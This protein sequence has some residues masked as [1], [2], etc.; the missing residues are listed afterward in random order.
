MTDAVHIRRIKARYRLQPSQVAEKRR[1]DSVLRKAAGEMLELALERAGVRSSE[2]ICIRTL[3][4]PVSLQ[5]SG[6]DSALAAEWATMLAKAIALAATDSLTCVRYRSHRLALID[7]GAN[8]AQGRLDRVWAWRQMGFWQRRE[9]PADLS[10]AVREFAEALR[11]EPQGIVAALAALARRGLLRPLAPYLEKSWPQLAFAVLEAGGVN[12]A[13]NWN[14]LPGNFVLAAQEPEPSGQSAQPGVGSQLGRV[15]DDRFREIAMQRARY[16]LGRSA[17]LCD[18]RNIHLPELEAKSLA[19]LALLECEPALSQVA[20]DHL[21][22][23]ADVICYMEFRRTST[24]LKR[25]NDFSRRALPRDLRSEANS[26]ALPL[27]S[28]EADRERLP[29]HARQPAEP[30]PQIESQGP[31]RSQAFTSFGGLLYLLPIVGALKIPER[32]MVSEAVA[33]RGLKWFQHRLA[34][35]LQPM[36]PDDPAALAFSGL[37]PAAED[38][39]RQQPPP[40]LEEQEFIGAMA[41]E[42]QDA[43]GKLFSEPMGTPEKLMQFVCRRQAQVVADP[44]WLEIRFSLDDVSVEIRRSG[45]DIDP[46]YLAWLGVVVKFIYE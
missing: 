34:L 6:A 5:L 32:A 36:E 4:V 14:T 10:T 31:L 11:R 3:N 26:K 27:K 1:L 33:T 46:G 8:I 20:V 29:E 25:P 42:V 38:P 22:A 41:A 43:L 13:A 7:M 9:S 23:A 18:L 30:S 17:I 21:L 28:A 19:M 37:G 40:S 12:V 15:R 35:T 44:G 2:I 39:S 24:R 45:L 16:T